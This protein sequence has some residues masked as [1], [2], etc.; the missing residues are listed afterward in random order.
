[1]KRKTTKAGGAK[2]RTRKPVAAGKAPVAAA[3]S[4]PGQAGPSRVLVTAV[5]IEAP[6]PHLQLR[7][8]GVLDESSM[9]G[10]FEKAGEEVRAAKAKRVLVDL[11]ECKVTLSISDMHGLV[12]M[13]ASE[14]SGTVERLSLL[15]QERDILPEKFFEPAL[16]SRGLPTL[17]TTDDEEALYWLSTKLRPGL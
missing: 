5:S 16:T 3:A 13:V 14:F 10:F 8:S 11:R 12:K 2:A 15:L 7:V 4:K 1:M 9:A 6:V 17:A